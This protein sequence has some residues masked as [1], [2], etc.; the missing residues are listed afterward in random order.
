MKILGIDTATATASV[1]LVEDG[2]LLLEEV[3]GGRHQRGDSPPATDKANHA[4]VLLPLI[5]RLLQRSAIPF[6]EIS[7][8]AISIGPGSFTGLR[9]G[10]STVKGLAYGW[11]TPVVAVA[12]LPAVAARVHDQDGLVCSI[13]DARKQEVYA[14]LFR[15]NGECLERLTEDLV[16]PP[17]RLLQRLLSS[18]YRD[19]CLFIGDGTKFYG[20]LIQS[21]LGDKAVLTAGDG[22]PSVAS[23]VARLAEERI[24]RKD[25]DSLGPLVPLYLRASEAE[26][27]VRL[28]GESC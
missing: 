13:L 26:L 25:F 21:Y 7:A 22:Y 2:R 12:T 24:R 15:K 6:S 23:S 17:G 20:E 16:S 5:D 10:L 27:K 18:G 28:W 9:I 8:V 11:E 19:P 4:E 14:A 1:A 3:G